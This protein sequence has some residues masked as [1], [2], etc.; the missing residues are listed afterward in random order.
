MIKVVLFDVDGVLVNSE[1]FKNIFRKDFPDIAEK[2]IPFFKNHFH[3]CVVGRKDLKEELK[4]NL[5]QWGWTE[6]V[7]DFLKYWFESEHRINESLITY[8]Q[9]LKISGIRCFLATNQD[10]YRSEYIMK[11]MGFGDIF[12]G[13]F[14][15]SS[16][17][18]NKE[19]VAFFEYVL[20]ELKEYKPSELLFW[21]D[22]KINIDSAFKTEIHAE[23]YTDFENFKRVMNDKYLFASL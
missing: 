22:L 1:G 11:E 6:G 20:G 3:D 21:D 19:D 23:L 16:I 2:S 17:G 8:I 13:I 9:N 5:Q 4:S 14:T 7:D 15:S 10:K 18:H 12:E